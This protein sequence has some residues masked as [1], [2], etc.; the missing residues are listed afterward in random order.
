MQ[1]NDLI[2]S[3]LVA[4]LKSKATILAELKNTDEIREDQWQGKEFSY[5]NIRVRLISNIPLQNECDGST[6]VASILVFSEEASSYQA[7][8]IAGIINQA[9]CGTNGKGKSFEYQSIRFSTFPQNLIPAIRQD[10]RT[11]RSEVLVTMTVNG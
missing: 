2:Q 4:Y 9:L 5:P 8:R 10:T 6:V 7:D 1:R 11:W 3:A